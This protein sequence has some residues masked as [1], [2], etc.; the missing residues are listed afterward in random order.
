MAAEDKGKI[1]EFFADIP[2]DLDHL[3]SVNWEHID[4]K[5][6]EYFKLGVSKITKIIGSA[7]ARK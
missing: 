6:D 1:T 2:L 4:R 7:G 3:K 5:D